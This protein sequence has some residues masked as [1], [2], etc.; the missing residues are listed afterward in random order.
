[1]A[2]VRPKTT[3]SAWR[4]DGEPLNVAAA[5]TKA[6]PATTISMHQL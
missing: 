6:E 3:K 5:P 1:M 4:L 2:T